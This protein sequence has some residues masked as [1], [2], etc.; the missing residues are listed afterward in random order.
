[1]IQ[2][3]ILN[4]SKGTVFLEDVIIAKS[5][6]A[7]LKGL[8]GKDNLEEDEGIIIKPCNSVHT[9]GMKLTIDVAFVDKNNKVIHII[10]EMP[11]GKFSPIIR[12]GVYAIEARAGTI[13]RKQLNIGDKLEIIESGYN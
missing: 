5:F 11:P 10:S 1:M 2:Y 4:L 9:I 8:L 7:R 13:E 12:G 3:K 6:F